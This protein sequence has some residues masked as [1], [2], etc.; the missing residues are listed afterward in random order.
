M[1]RPRTAIT[2][3][4]V[5]DLC[6]PASHLHTNIPLKT[7][8]L[9]TNM[10]ASENPNNNGSGR[11]CSSSSSA[12]GRDEDQ[13]RMDLASLLP[14]PLPLP[15]HLEI[16]VLDTQNPR[17]F[18]TRVLDAAMAIADE[19]QEL[20]ENNDGSTSSFKSTDNDPDAGKKRERE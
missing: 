12:G 14:P 20:F 17:E 16:P 9:S 19:H 10:P 11:G 13:L 5:E 18:L 2:G 1:P 8:S 4:S 6:F 3:V 7:L 15:P